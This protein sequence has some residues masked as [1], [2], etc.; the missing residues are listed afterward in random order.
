[1]SDHRGQDC[2][3]R[4]HPVSQTIILVACIKHAQ[5]ESYGKTKGKIQQ[6]AR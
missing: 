1:M 2:A 6:V 4:F 5:E 3:E